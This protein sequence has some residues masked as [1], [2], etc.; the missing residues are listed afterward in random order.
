[1]KESK[2]ERIHKEEI[3]TKRK[4]TQREQAIKG[5]RCKERET[6]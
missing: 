6:T 4:H 1:M 3:A 5:E 2:K